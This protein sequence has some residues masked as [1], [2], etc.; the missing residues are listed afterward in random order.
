MT[1][2]AQGLYCPSRVQSFRMRAAWIALLIA[3]VSMAPC[4]AIDDTSQPVAILPCPTANA[5][6]QPSKADLKKAKEAFHRGLK[7]ENQKK[8]DEAF[9]EFD[10]AAR[11]APTNIDYVTALALLRQQLVSEHIQKGNAALMKNLP[12]EAQAEFRSA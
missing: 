7:L 5:S 2:V 11:L 10:T 8:M 1:C 6:C 4:Y 9:T 3:V 12:V